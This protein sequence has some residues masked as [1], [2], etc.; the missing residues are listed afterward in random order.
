[1]L[2][3]RTHCID[4]LIHIVIKSIEILPAGVDRSD[5]VEI[6]SNIGVKEELSGDEPKRNNRL[7]VDK[8]TQVQ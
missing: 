7:S 1:M 3:Q 4:H 5:A 6:R 2:L 8:L